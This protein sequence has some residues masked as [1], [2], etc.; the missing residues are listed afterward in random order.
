MMRPLAKSEVV[1]ESTIPSLQFEKLIG[2]LKYAFLI[3]P[4]ARQGFNKTYTMQDA[5]LSA[6]SVFFMQCPSF[7]AYQKQMQ[8]TKGENNAASLFQADSI[9]SDNQIRNLLDSVDPSN[10]NHVYQNIFNQLHS[11]GLLAKYQC[12]NDT[13]LIA[14][15]GVCYHSSSTVF[16]DNCNYQKH[17][18][19]TTTYTHSAITPVIVAPG[20][21]HVISLPPEFLTPQDG[22]DKQD[23][24]HAA[25]KRWLKMHA[26][27]YRALGITILGDDLY[28]HQ[29]ICE[30]ILAEQCHFLLTCKPDSHKT[31]YEWVADLERIGKVQTY[32][33]TW[34]HGKKHFTDTYRFINGVPLRDSDD[35]LFVNW[36]E[37]VTTNALGEVVYKNAFATDHLLSQDN[38]I[39]VVKAGRARWKIENENNNTLKTKGYNIGHNFGHGSQH[40]SQLLL[41]LN[42]LA[43]LYHT[44]LNLVDISYQLIR[45]KLPSRKAF[46]EHVRVLTHYM[47]FQNWQALMQFMM[48]GLEIELPNSG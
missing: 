41:S 4:D 24:E 7:L 36:C 13:L 2:Y 34:R 10:L 48:H 18:N 22:H 30:A 26:A 12:L 43:F 47:Y 15:D 25:I 20:N 11:T 9:P 8:I 44:V 33:V 42:L 16:C 31:L 5:A 17:K 6:F 27:S 38:I 45:A 19:G 37:L 1:V 14:I 23:G 40:L 46:F 32:T 35:A 3:L 29:P 28:A 39:D 21:E